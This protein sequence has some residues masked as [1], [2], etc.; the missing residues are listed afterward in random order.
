MFR[1]WGA[2]ILCGVLSACGEDLAACPG[3]DAGEPR[4]DAGAA[5]DDEGVLGTPAVTITSASERNEVPLGE[6]L[7]LE[8]SVT[9]ARD[10]LE[11]ARV[12]WASSNEAIASVSVSGV[13]SARAVGEV[14]IRASALGVTGYLIVKVTDALL[15]HMTIDPVELRLEAIGDTAQL[16]VTGFDRFGAERALSPDVLEW[17][18]AN[19]LVASIDANGKVTAHGRGATILSAR[20]EDEYVTARLI[21]QDPSPGTPGFELAEVKA[22][23]SHTCGA[24][25][26]GTAY[27]W[28]DN[29]YGEV[30]S[31]EVGWQASVPHRVSGNHVFHG[32][33]AST[34]HS[35]ALDASGAAYCWGWNPWGQLG[36]PAG[37]TSA[38][39]IAVRGGLSFTQ[40]AAG[41]YHTCALDTQGKAYCFGSGHNGGL[42]NGSGL[43]QFVPTP[44]SGNH[45]FAQI[46]AGYSNTCA[47]TTEG[48]AYCWGDDSLGTG[49]FF[50][51]EPE[52]V[53]GGLVFTQL[54]LSDDH[55]CALTAEGRAYCWGDNQDGQLGHAGGSGAPVP[56]AGEQRFV[57]ISAGSGHSCAISEVGEAWCWGNNSG[58]QL[59][60]GTIEP[61]PVPVK[62]AGELVFA[63]ITAGS[64]HTCGRTV[65]GQVHC[66]GQGGQ[67]EL[68]AGIGGHGAYSI[69]PWPV[70]TP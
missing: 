53:L 12:E 3:E 1:W 69:V 29:E 14:E 35:C 49:H 4:P 8:A 32:V 37:E 63:S 34:F 17:S 65:E 50:A 45:R 51:S 30:G 39:P 23:G 28:G 22:G 64:D 54:D 58:G 42:G 62:V 40:I 52:P 27:C 44:V 21:V 31:G 70:T 57:A 68:G 46:R 56:V 47:L 33:S 48:A 10:Q 59:G 61:R 60:D 6:T 19:Q 43:D 18:S 2:A 36:D 38:V 24:S 13:V 16:V 15:D 25:A 11:D 5:V 41:T 55:V 7:A 67:G 20:Y 9:N 26:A 66:W